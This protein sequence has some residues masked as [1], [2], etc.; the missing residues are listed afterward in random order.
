MWFNY[1]VVIHVKPTN[2]EHLEEGIYEFWQK[3][4]DPQKC[5]NYIHHLRVAFPKVIAAEGAQ[6]GE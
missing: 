6:T 4:M 5:R 1:L 2:L 3:K